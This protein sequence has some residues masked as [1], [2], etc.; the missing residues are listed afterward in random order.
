LETRNGTT[1]F[2]TQRSQVAAVA[3]P[4]AITHQRQQEPDDKRD[5]DRPTK[6][7]PLRAKRHGLSDGRAATSRP[8]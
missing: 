2:R 8:L 6:I 7:A 1:K 5:P 4:E 3:C